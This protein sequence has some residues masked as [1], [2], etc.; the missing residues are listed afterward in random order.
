VQE[1][2]DERVSSS[3]ARRYGQLDDESAAE[4]AAHPC[5]FYGWLIWVLLTIAQITTFFG[6]SSAVTFVVEPMMADLSLSRSLLSLSYGVATGVGAAAQIPIGRLVDRFG[7]RAGVV[8][9]SAAFYVSLVAMAAPQ[10]W[11]TLT[12]AFGAMRA[13]GFGGLALACN[14][15]L[16][17]WFVRRRALLAHDPSISELPS[18]CLLAADWP[19]PIIQRPTDRAS[20]P[21]AGLRPVS[22]SL[23]IRWWASACAR[24]SI[25]WR[26]SKLAGAG[27]TSS[28]VR[29]SCST[30]RWPLSC[31]DRSP[32]T[33]DWRQMAISRPAP[34]SETGQGTA[35]RPRS[36]AGR[37]VRRGARALCG[38][39]SQATRS[40]G[41][42]ALV[43]SSTW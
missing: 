28:L 41:A 5:C 30:R 39:S 43:S 36:A 10:D 27:R 16:Q 1:R 14:T 40:C 18:R 4:S 29:A 2:A 8:V 25:R 21:Q 38:S 32:R 42:S 15:C 20:P 24:S 34:A 33:S 11:V 26:C 22:V 37:S 35:A 6:T 7:G 17:N 9:C 13:L 3:R 12:F 31:C 23:R 19:R